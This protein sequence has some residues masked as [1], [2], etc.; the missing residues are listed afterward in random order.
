MECAQVTE[1]QRLW[2]ETQIQKSK[3]QRLAELS[4]L[5]LPDSMHVVIP[6]TVGTYMRAL[7]SST[8]VAACLQRMWRCMWEEGEGLSLIH[9]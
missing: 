3:A 9:I 2:T 1:E 7:Y 5:S 6:T 8:T 4:R